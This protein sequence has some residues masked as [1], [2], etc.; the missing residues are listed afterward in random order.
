[1]DSVL[2]EHLIHSYEEA[3][4]AEVIII[5]FAP[6]T[7]GPFAQKVLQCKPVSPIIQNAQS[8]LNTLEKL[9]ATTSRQEEEAEPLCAAYITTLVGEIL[10]SVPMV[11]VEH[12]GTSAVQRILMYCSEHYSENISIRQTA[13]AIGLSESYVTKIFSSKVGCTF[14]SY[15][16]S[17]RV[18]DAKKLLQDTDRKITDIM[19]SCGYDNQSSFNSAFREDTGMTPREYRSWCRKG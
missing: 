10:L 18:S 4:D 9:V 11:P 3:P 5:L 13:D 12:L 19:L 15:I 1:M 14:R 17:L 2:C 6:E 16:N 8:Y 7:A